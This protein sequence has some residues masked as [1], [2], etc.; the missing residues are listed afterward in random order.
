MLLRYRTELPSERAGMGSLGCGR[1]PAVLPQPSCPVRCLHVQD[2]VALVR[3]PIAP[4][5][6]VPRHREMRPSSGSPPGAFSEH[7]PTEGA[8]GRTNFSH[9]THYLL[10]TFHVFIKHYT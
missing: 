7:L 1:V 2:P 3:D 6:E 9:S 4:A 5:R 10:N 8:P